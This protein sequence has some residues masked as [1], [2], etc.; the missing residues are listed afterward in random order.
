VKESQS[1]EKMASLAERDIDQSL[2]SKRDVGRS[3]NAPITFGVA[4]TYCEALHS[5]LARQKERQLPAA[6]FVTLGRT[7]VGA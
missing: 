4:P 6:Q 7:P 1:G 3:E 2:R 5:R